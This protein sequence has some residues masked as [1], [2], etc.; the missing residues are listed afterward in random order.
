MTYAAKPAA[1][2]VIRARTVGNDERGKIPS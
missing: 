2:V 1:A